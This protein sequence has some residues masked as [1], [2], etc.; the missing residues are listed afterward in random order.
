MNGA[1]ITV[2]ATAG[3]I[4]L[5]KHGDQIEHFKRV[6][7][8]NGATA[9]DLDGDNTLTTGTGYALAIGEVV[10]F[11]L[12]PGDAVYGITAAGTSV[13]SVLVGGK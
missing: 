4:L 13:V 8:K 7:I 5:A 2:P 6:V 9:I 12:A 3:G 1:R 10:S 11:D